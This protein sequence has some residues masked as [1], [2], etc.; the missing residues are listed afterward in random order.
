MTAPL[1]GYISPCSGHG[2]ESILKRTWL[3]GER[4]TM[5]STFRSSS[6]L[7]G[8]AATGALFTCFAIVL[9]PFPLTKAPTP[10]LK[11]FQQEAFQSSGYPQIKVEREPQSKPIAQLAVKVAAT[12]APD[13]NL[14]ETPTTPDS[15]DNRTA[16]AQPTIVGVWAPDAK[17]LHGPKF[18]RRVSSNYN[19]YGRR[20]G[21]RYVLY[22]QKSKK[23]RN[24][25]GSDR[26]LLQWPR[27]VDSPGPIVRQGRPSDLDKQARRPNLYAMHTRFSDGRG[28][29]S[30]GPAARHDANV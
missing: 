28:A 7:Y 4:A 23:D 12:S 9:N 21:W 10:D 3:P 15:D 19:Q 6:I 17:S 29:I 20:M 27:T 25:L 13:R 14:E 1:R 8:F 30:L 24:R 18:S 2:D 11:G 22:F 16:Q 26:E 5:Q